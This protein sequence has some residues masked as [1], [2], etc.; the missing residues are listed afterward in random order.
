MLLW[1][2]DGGG[3]YKF[4]PGAIYKVPT[5][6]KLV[7]PELLASTYTIPY[8]LLI[9]LVEKRKRKANWIDVTLL[10]EG[11]IILNEWLF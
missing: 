5:T 9:A 6:S 7:K 10:F 8:P 4:C 2:L 3:T 1:S 11:K